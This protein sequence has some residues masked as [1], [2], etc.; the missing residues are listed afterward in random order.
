M[1]AKLQLILT[2][3]CTKNWDDLPEAGP[4]RYCD[5]C[6]K[7][8]VDLSDKSDAE[9]ILF[10]Q[11]KKDNVCGRLLSGQLNRAL[12][13]PIQKANW[14]WLLPLA[15]GA[16]FTTPAKATEL[17]PVTHVIDH[18]QKPYNPINENVRT[19][20][21]TDTVGGKVIDQSTGKPL[22]GVK[23]KQKGFQ[24]VLA[25]SDSTGRFELAQSGDTLSSTYTFE[26]PN[27]SSLDWKVTDGMEVKMVD[28]RRIRIGGVSV[29]GITTTGPLIV[30]SSGKQ[31]CNVNQSKFQEIPQDWIEE[32]EILKDA[33]ATV[34]YGAKGANGVVL[35][36]IKKAYAKNIDFS[37][38]K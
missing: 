4:G 28:A 38:G 17:R 8:I 9:L 23:V 3:P 12:V 34:L 33:Q 11:K 16:I 35:V 25:V 31:T 29:A 27:Y 37:K 18:S 2:N 10:F 24:N 1:K 14:G 5:S 36:K 19:A 26:L 22:A 15:V 21:K 13:P 6:E 30:L 32:I 20:S 7:H